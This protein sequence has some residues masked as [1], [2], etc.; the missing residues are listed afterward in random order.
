MT[1]SILQKNKTKCFLCRGNANYEPLDLHHV[2]LGANRK[3]SDKY[4]L[5][6][7]LHHNTCHI[8]GENSVHGNA[9]VM[10]ILQAHAQRAAMAHYGWS[11]KDFI[12][13]FGKNYL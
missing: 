4:G 8:F 2:F 7:Y 9:K 13:I 11:T 10:R 6:V 3:L 12:K 1:K 5:T